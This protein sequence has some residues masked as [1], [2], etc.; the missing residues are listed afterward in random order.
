MNEN[1]TVLIIDDDP[2]IRQ[3]LELLMASSGLA[4]RTYES[5]RDFLDAEKPE[6][7]ACVLLDL[8]MPDMDGM[9]VQRQLQEQDPSL[10]V[11]FLTGHGDVPVAVR[12]LKH[13]A[14]DFFQKPDFDHQEL[15]QTIRQALTAHEATLS[16]SAEQ[17]RIRDGIDSLSRRELEVARLAAAGKANKV[18][19]IEL[20]ISERTVEV[21]R[22][23]AMKKLGLRRA[24]D[25]VRAEPTL[26][27]VA[28]D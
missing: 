28:S 25:L 16:T 5:G 18:I 26:A 3:A 20:G 6:G 19:G 11:I 10:P 9:E 7:A 13:G 24:A 27:E 21:H 15:L 14:M 12:A 17:Q 4:A 22:G 2:G 23:R 8:S 1:A